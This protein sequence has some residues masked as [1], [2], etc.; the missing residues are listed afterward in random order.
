MCDRN[1]EEWQDRHPCQW[2]FPKGGGDRQDREKTSRWQYVGICI[3]W[4][5]FFFFWLGKY[6]RKHELFRSIFKIEL[7]LFNPIF[8][9]GA[10][11]TFRQDVPRWLTRPCSVHYGPNSPELRVGLPQDGIPLQK[12]ILLLLFSGSCACV[13]QAAHRNRLFHSVGGKK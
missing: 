12:N 3:P 4:A 6:F 2:P 1:S 11:S 8:L 9:G 13:V 10:F 5:S 7:E